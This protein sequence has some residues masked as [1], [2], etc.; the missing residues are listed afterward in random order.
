[1][2]ERFGPRQ[3]QFQS[4]H[5]VLVRVPFRHVL[6]TNYDPV[7]DVAHAAAFGAPPV[8]I[9]AKSAPDFGAFV[10]QAA[11]SRGYGRRY[12]STCTAGSTRPDS[13]ILTEEDYQQRYVREGATQ[14]LGSVKAHLASGHQRHFAILASEFLRS[15][16]RLVA[17]EDM[18]S[19]LV[20]SE[21]HL[22]DEMKLAGRTVL[23]LARRARRSPK[24]R[25]ARG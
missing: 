20:N 2:A 6:I 11:V 14:A 24:S 13:I 5:D 10:Q 3:P 17:G 25:G 12:Y 15:V 16:Y 23:V 7:L 8:V 21:R 1:M 18:P 9:N 22:V 4:F 19:E